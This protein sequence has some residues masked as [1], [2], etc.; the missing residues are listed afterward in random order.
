MNSTVL[1]PMKRSLKSLQEAQLPRLDWRSFIKVTEGELSY[2][3]V[4]A[5]DNYFRQFVSNKDG[6][7][8]C[9]AQQGAKDIVDAF[10]CKARFEWGLANGE[11]FCGA[12]KY[13]AR[14]YHRNVGPIKFFQ[15]IL[16]YH[17][18]E[19]VDKSEKRHRSEH[20]TNADNVARVSSPTPSAP[21]VGAVE[22]KISGEK[23]A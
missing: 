12:C 8:M 9:G 3:D 2:A 18:D 1:R 22:Q 20:V 16:Q 10:L 5:L 13:P 14:A 23:E 6:C 19:L 11:G 4:S 17:P 15:A 7:I 21:S